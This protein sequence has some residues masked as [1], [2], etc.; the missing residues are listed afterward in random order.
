MEKP[1]TRGAGIEKGDNSE[2]NLTVRKGETAER[3][4]VTARRLPYRTDSP[5]S[6]HARGFLITLLSLPDDWKHSIRG[7]A[8]LLG[9]DGLDSVQSAKKELE[10]H[11]YLTVRRLSTGH[12]EWT[13][14]EY[15]DGP[16]VEKPH[17]GNP[18]LGFPPQ[19]DK[20][21]EEEVVVGPSKGEPPESQ[22]EP[23]PPQDFEEPEKPGGDN[24]TSA[25]FPQVFR[26]A[27]RELNPA[28]TITRE[29]EAEM[30]RLIRQ[31]VDPEELRLNIVSWLRGRPECFNL[32]FYR[33]DRV[34]AQ[35]SESPLGRVTDKARKEAEARALQARNT[36]RA[37][38]ADEIRRE[39][40]AAPNPG[41][42]DSFL[43]TVGA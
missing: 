31:G 20:S 39:K 27:L 5:L 10:K 24:D 32:R 18:D 22:E 35:G 8:A 28:F 26:D 33:E 19:E 15:P 25:L 21:K 16:P 29:D 11:G 30:A 2:R 7:F 3:Y 40:E 4:Y 9:A 12:T 17:L 6:L 1:V 41:L 37:R 34:F 42:L 38:E 36:D 23:P 14:N 43:R 13:V